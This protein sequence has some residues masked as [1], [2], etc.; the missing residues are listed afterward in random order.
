MRRGWGGVTGLVCLGGDV[1]S[2]G[3]R[4]ER[5]LSVQSREENPH[6]PHILFVDW[7]SSVVVL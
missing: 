4:E 5:S 3:G 6:A 2:S 7:I 1:G